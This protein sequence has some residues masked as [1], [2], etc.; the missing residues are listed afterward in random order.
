VI[1]MTASGHAEQ[2]AD[3]LHANGYLDKPL[4]L[5]ALIAEVRR[6]AH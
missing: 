1:V 4:A 6:F 5:D 3:A 2:K